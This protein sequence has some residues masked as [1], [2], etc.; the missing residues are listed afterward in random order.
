MNEELK[1]LKELKERLESPLN[2]ASKEKMEDKA[3]E[4]VS[5]LM[6]NYVITKGGKE[7]E[8]IETEFY[9]YSPSH[10]DITVYDRDM[11]SGRFFF[12]QSGLDITFKSQI[13]RINEKIDSQ[14]SAFGGILIRALRQMDGKTFILGPINCVN[15]LWDNF[16]ALEEPSVSEYPYLRP[17]SI[18][19]IECITAEKRHYPI[20]DAKKADKVKSLNAKF[21]KEVG[22]I[23]DLNKWLECK[24]R[25]VR[26]DIKPDEKS[27]KKYNRKPYPCPK[28]WI[29]P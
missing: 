27:L 20:D 19:N 4:I 9:Y 28:T 17:N 14:K 5:N 29:K 22:K 1:K 6:L 11:D 10:Q 21:D 12:H 15:H 8:I 26:N 3:K 7:Y 16:N 13:E 18:G 24:Y 23:E 2:E 25:F